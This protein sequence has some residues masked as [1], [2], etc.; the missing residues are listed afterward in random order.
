MAGNVD[1]NEINYNQTSLPDLEGSYVQA[2]DA[3]GGFEI[4]R[5]SEVEEPAEVPESARAWAFLDGN[6]EVVA[7][8]PEGGGEEGD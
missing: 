5:E 8:G 3:F 4:P 6:F 2:E 7:Q 1:T